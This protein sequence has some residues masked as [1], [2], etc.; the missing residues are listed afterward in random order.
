M[1][2]VLLIYLTQSITQRGGGGVKRQAGRYKTPLREK[3]RADG[4]AKRESTKY[5]Y[6]RIH[7]K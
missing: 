7:T 6:Q 3:Y 2:L 1:E 4:H 5:L